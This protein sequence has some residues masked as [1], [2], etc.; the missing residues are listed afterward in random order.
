MIDGKAIEHYAR[1]IELWKDCD[2]EL[3][4]MVEEAKKQLE[5]L[6]QKNINK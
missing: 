1:F 6:Q 4:Q 3:R 2:P 5:L